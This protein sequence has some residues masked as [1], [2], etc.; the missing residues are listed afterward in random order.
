MF[1]LGGHDGSVLVE[2]DGRGFVITMAKME[3]NVYVYGRW[4]AGILKCQAI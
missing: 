1:Q 2:R 3:Q 4:R